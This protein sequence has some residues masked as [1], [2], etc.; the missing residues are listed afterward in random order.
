MSVVDLKRTGCGIAQGFGGK[1]RVMGV[2]HMAVAID[3]FLPRDNGIGR[4]AFKI[5]QSLTAI[6]KRPVGTVLSLGI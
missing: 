5:P 3:I 2:V 6:G 1:G 4:G